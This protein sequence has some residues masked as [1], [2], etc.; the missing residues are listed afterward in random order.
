MKNYNINNNNEN[1]STEDDDDKK[2]IEIRLNK[3]KY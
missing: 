1:D 3:W 2:L